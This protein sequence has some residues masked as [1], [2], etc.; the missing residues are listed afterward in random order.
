MA[1]EN[2]K[3]VGMRDL[4]VDSYIHRLLKMS[5][6]YYPYLATGA[7][8]E[9]QSE[10]PVGI[11]QSFGKRKKIISF[12][13]HTRT[14]WRPSKIPPL[15]PHTL[16]ITIQLPASSTLLAISWAV[17]GVRG[18]LFNPS[19]RRSPCASIGIWDR[20]HCDECVRS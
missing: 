7:T 9:K 17:D 13:A 4:A 20:G 5:V 19:H 3:V 18:Q 10:K 16:S 8:F 2:T 15:S 12:S 6:T 1:Y 14:P 11:S